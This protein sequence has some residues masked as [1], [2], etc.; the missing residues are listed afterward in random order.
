M[1]ALAGAHLSPRV[2]SLLVTAQLVLQV[3]SNVVSYACI[4][5]SWQ[6][7]IRKVIFVVFSFNLLMASN[8]FDINLV[9]FKNY[10][11]L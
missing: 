9:V 1:R 7:W 10:Y 11:I 2:R 6:D 5:V 3:V 4:A 8:T